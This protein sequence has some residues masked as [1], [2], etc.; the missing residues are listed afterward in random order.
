MGSAHSSGHSSAH[1]SSWGHSRNASFSHYHSYGDLGSNCSA[2]IQI[3]Q[4]VF[5]KAWLQITRLVAEYEWL[6]HSTSC[7]D[8]V[9][10]VTVKNERGIKEKI[11]KITV[12]ITS[13]ATKL[14]SYKMRIETAYRVEARL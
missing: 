14:E 7:P 6:I 2:Q 10:E 4:V 1:S 13:Y 3:L 9:K 12:K 8:F 11:E 5:I